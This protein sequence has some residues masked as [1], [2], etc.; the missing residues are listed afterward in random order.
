[1][2]EKEA[3]KLSALSSEYLDCV[4]EIIDHDDVKSMKKYNQHGSVD[5][6]QHC[7]NVSTASYLI[8]KKLKLDYRSAARGGLLHDFFLYDWHKENPHGGLHAFTH[9]KVA[10]QNADKTFTLNSRE[11]DVIKNHMW[12]LTVSFP[13]YPE[14]LIVVLVDKFYCIREVFKNRGNKVMRELRGFAY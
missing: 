7:L 12:P 5:C 11:R 9:P 10:A 14:T 4:Q 1:M 3:E 6:F 8:C 13:R 2:P